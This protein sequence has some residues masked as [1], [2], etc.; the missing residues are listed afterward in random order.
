MGWSV[1]AY[2]QYIS[3]VIVDEKMGELFQLFGFLGVVAGGV[4][5]FFEGFVG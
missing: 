4:E 3:V 2:V 1:S 5:S